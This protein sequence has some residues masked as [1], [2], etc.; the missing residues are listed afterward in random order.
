MEATDTLDMKG[1][2]C[3][4]TG[5]TGGIGRVTAQALAQKGATV[6]VVARNSQ[7]A[8]KVVRQ[9][10]EQTGN[11]QVDYLIGDL[12]VQS[13]VRRVA[14]TFRARYNRLDVLINNAGQYFW[15]RQLSKDGIEMTFAL[16]HLAYFL[17][18]HLL[19]DMLIAS[20]PAR[21]V[22]VSS[23]AH[24]GARLNLKDLQNKHW[25][26]GWTVYGRSK[27][28]NLY[29][30]YELARR[31]KGTGVTV[32]ALHPGFVAT[33]FGRSNGGIF[34]LIFKIG[35]IAAITPE[36]GAQTSIYLATSPEVEGVTGLYFRKCKPIPSSP[37]SYREDI[38]RQLWQVSEEMTGLSHPQALDRPS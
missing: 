31:L 6:V 2:I 1:K 21:I 5:G 8:E 28:A 22:N 23:V 36:Q 4:V 26:F 30:T 27:L 9:I 14:E 17:L 35:Q 15:K 29:F 19:L 10:R 18:T 32:N 3:L 37:V 12:S 38:A 34:D 25:V 7:K 33:N 16:N 20:A 13:D 24:L 11:P